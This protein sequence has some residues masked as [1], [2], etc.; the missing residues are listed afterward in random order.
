[1][2]NSTTVL[3]T[4]IQKII[5][6]GSL[7]QLVNYV[8]INNV[9]WNMM[10]IHALLLYAIE[11]NASFDIIKYFE[12]RYGATETLE[13]LL[14]HNIKKFQWLFNHHKYHNSY[15]LRLLYLSKYHIKTSQDKLKG[16]VK[17][18]QNQ[19]IISKSMY[20]YALQKSYNSIL[21]LFLN[22]D[23]RESIIAI[24]KKYNLLLYSVKSNQYEML[25][26]L[27]NHLNIHHQKI[28]MPLLLA[29]IKLGHVDM[30]K[31]LLRH[32]I[33]INNNYKNGFTPLMY[34]I[35][36]R[37]RHIIKCLLEAKADINCM[38]N[39]GN[40]ALFI[41]LKNGLFDVMKLLIQYGADV[42]HVNHNDDTVLMIAIKKKYDKIA[43]FL[44]DEG[45]DVNARDSHGDT[46]LLLA[47]KN[48]N[49]DMVEYLLAHG[50][51]I[52]DKDINGNTPLFIAYCNCT[53]DIISILMKNKANVNEKNNATGI[54]VLMLTSQN[55]FLLNV[56]YLVENGA[57]VNAT[58]RYGNSVLDYA[59]KN[60]CFHN[61]I[62]TYLKSH[63]AC[64]VTCKGI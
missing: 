12:Y 59:S 44:I 61:E 47:I 13:Y 18:E 16:I 48:E 24:N 51:N 60:I 54:T 2:D 33:D 35:F 34:A 37:Q 21:K 23:T 8:N 46:I 25:T 26:S 52:N 4:E 10:E 55:G 38:D 50:A 22:S 36:Y 40:T 31:L 11:Q 53:I 1:M 6:K 49:T 43:K 29:S 64:D 14:K 58:D 5:N 28:Y 20:A 41:A 32:R 62:M 19:I 9:E 15:V 3:T 57:N 56:K 42:N 27:L 30:V 39:H 45:A 63:G 17:E 7:V